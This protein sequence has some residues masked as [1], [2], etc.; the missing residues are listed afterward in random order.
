MV[1]PCWLSTITF[2]LLLDLTCTRQIALLI[3]DV[4]NCFLPGGSL[5]V[6]EGDQ[7]IPVINNIRSEY[8]ADISLVV[9]S[10]DWHCSDHISFASQHK[11]AGQVIQLSYDKSGSLCDE[12]NSCT[13]VAYNLTQHLWPDHCVINTPSANFSHNLTH[14]PSDLV[15]R[16]GYN[17]KVDSY[18]A[19]YD[20]GGFRHTEMHD[21]LQED[22]IDALIITGLARDYCVYY[23]AMDSKKLGYETYVVLDATRPVT[24]ETGDSAVA[25]MKIKGIQIIESPDVARVIAQLTSDAKYLKSSILMIS[26]ILCLFKCLIGM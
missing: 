2:I 8:K 24:K 1:S 17:C 4:Q 13:E 26:I 6:T 25:D 14:E 16:K 22:G 7:V 9:L 5:A 20:N 19:F 11:G 15:V 10:Q 21:K 3:I 12:N 23:T 18:S